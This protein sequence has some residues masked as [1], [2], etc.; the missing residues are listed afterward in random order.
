[1]KLLNFL[2]VSFSFFEKKNIMNIVIKKNI[3]H[4]KIRSSVMGVEPILVNICYYVL[5]TMPI[6]KD[7]NRKL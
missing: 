6:H 3:W 7:I 5:R 1:M 2:F 4:R